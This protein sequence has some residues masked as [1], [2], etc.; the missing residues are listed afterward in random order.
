MGGAFTPGLN[1]TA[2]TTIRRTRL[3]PI[4]GQVLVT[5]GDAVEAGTNVARVDMPGTLAVA[6]VVQALG[7]TADQVEDLCAVR[8][9]DRVVR[10]QLIASRTFL[11]GLVTHRCRSPRDGTVEYISK[12][13]GN[14]GI[15]GNPTPVTCSAYIAGTVVEVIA[16][17]GVVVETGGALIQGIFGV[18]G[19]RHGEL[20]WLGENATA[21]RGNAI[22]PAH[23]G[24]ILIHPG[25]IDGSCLAVAAEQGVVGLVGASIVDA[26]LMGYLGY[27]IGVAITGQEQIPFSLV[28]TEGFGEMT[29]P[30]RTRNILQAL[31][32]CSAA[33]NGATQI[34][35]GVIRPEIIVPRPGASA[36]PAAAGAELAIGTR[37]RCIR[38]PH[39]GRLGRIESLPAQPVAVGTGSL[40]RVMTVRLDDGPVVTIPRA[41]AEL[42]LGD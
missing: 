18:G 38:R 7:C 25:R 42:L 2:H 28:L 14:V 31:A 12:L 40:V 35:A 6:K 21:L 19:E 34:R 5:V 30:T 16:E 36:A 37:V 13:S 15:R 41:N 33:I 32:G 11:F 1:V 10:N 3:L 8:E 39:F 26:D 23:R 17:E 24:K 27:D 22:T 29:M 20:A 9:G 4:R